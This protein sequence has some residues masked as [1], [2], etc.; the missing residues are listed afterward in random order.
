MDIF[1][2]EYILLFL[3]FQVLVYRVLPESARRYWLGLVSLL[4][5][6]SFGLW[7]MGVALLVSLITHL[8]AIRITGSAAT[9]IKK[10]WCFAG[11]GAIV[12]ILLLSRIADQ[13]TALGVPARVGLSYYGLMCIAYLADVY[14]DR[15]SLAADYFATVLYTAYFPQLVAGPISKPADLLPQLGNLTLPSQKVIAVG[16]KRILYGLFCKLVVADRMGSLVDPILDERGSADLWH[17][18]AASSGYSL[19]IYFDF[20]GYSF[21]VVGISRLFG[22]EI[23]NNFN[24]PYLATSTREFWRRWHISLTDWL[25]RYLYLPLGGNRNRRL[26]PLT[27]LIV[28]CVSGLWHGFERRYLFWGMMHAFAYLLGHYLGFFQRFSSLFSAKVF[29]LLKWLLFLMWLNLTWAVFR[30]NKVIE[31]LSHSNGS[32]FEWNSLNFGNLAALHYWII[33]ALVALAVD[34]S[35]IPDSVINGEGRGRMG[36]LR[37]IALIDV[38]LVSLFFLGGI[39]SKGVLYFNF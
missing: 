6:S 22:I 16:L 7:S 31:L 33:A 28:F 39:G 27:I 37:E 2:A 34:H 14:S 4:F 19:Q 13:T 29:I 35:G 26:F 11:I 20:A 21:L 3:P 38:W 9:R 25:R 17:F 24:R 23:V 36:L 10:G 8:V 1:S 5:L 12:G 15:S 30:S 18:V 32:S